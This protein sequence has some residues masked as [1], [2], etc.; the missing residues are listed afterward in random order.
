VKKLPIRIVDRV[1]STTQ[2][3]MRRATARSRP[4]PDFILIGTQRA[5]TTSLFRD[6]RMH[7]Q[8]APPIVKEIHFYD[9][10]HARGSSWYQAHF[11]TKRE[12]N[13]RAKREGM[14]ISGEATPNYLRHPHAARWAAAELPEASRFI[15]TLRNPVD[16]AFSHW[17]LMVRLGLEDLSFGDAIEAEDRR[18]GPDW[19]RV[20]RDPHHQA[21]EYFRHSYAARGRY[22]EQLDEWFRRVGRDRVHVVRTEDHYARPDETYA[23]ITAFLG[24]RSWQPERFSDIHATSAS[25][26]PAD[27]ADHLRRE[28][29]QH[30]ERLGELMERDFGWDG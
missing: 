12:R 24:L 16:R 10:N 29:A 9:Y 23:E 27:V 22:A 19:E 8:V 15:V 14:A 1:R 18:I 11:P 30:N 6:L 3:A 20:Q 21:H 13:E 28:F 17:K 25:A 2:L 5:G 4:G 7:P 26:P